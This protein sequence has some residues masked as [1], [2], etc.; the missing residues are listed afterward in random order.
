MI[1]PFGAI[2]ERIPLISRRQCHCVGIVALLATTVLAQPLSGQDAGPDSRMSDP[3]PLGILEEEVEALRE[4][5]PA[6]LGSSLLELASGYHFQGRHD[7]ALGVG[8]A[9]LELL[10]SES[11]STQI[12]EAHH[13]VGL[14]H[15]NLVQYDSAVTHLSLA[16]RVWLALDDREA[17]GRVHNNLGAAHYQWGNYELALGSFL[18]SLQ[19][20]REVGSEAGQALALTNV[21]LTYH[22]WG[23]Y[24]RAGTALEDAIELADRAGYLFG[25]AYARLNL[26]ELR[27]TQGELDEAEALF[28]ESTRYYQ[29]GAGQ[30]VA[31]DVAGGLLLNSLG[32][33][34]VQVHRGEADA[35]IRLLLAALDASREREHLRHEARTQ[36]DLGTAYQAAGLYELAFEH[37]SEGLAVATRRNQRPVAVDILSNLS[38]VE[39]S[40]GFPDR[41]LEHLRA[42]VALRDSI[43]SQGAAQRVA[44]ME[45]Q[46]EIDRQQLENALLREEQRVREATLRRQR[47]IATLAAGLFLSAAL[48]AGMLVH[49]NRR[50][51]ERE[52]A[53]AESNRSLE[54]TNRELR[55]TRIEIQTLG[56]LIPICSRCKR[57][58]DDEGYWESVESY[59]S[60][61]SDAFF[62]HSIC[63]DCG[64]G[65]FKEDWVAPV[66]EGEESTT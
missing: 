52:K 44:A 37:L 40:R 5:S 54:E 19:Y 32:L 27:L 22:D 60:S 13:Q 1:G 31:S 55:R 49:A 2:R 25:Q 45:A 28:A 43:F 23:Q 6:R 58:R 53:L 51:R 21:G 24:D 57:V 38:E 30:L 36:H 46:T 12:A 10:R 4:A 65:L 9:A 8:R 29:E 63:T 59:V 56:G 18:E 17:L 11:D 42:H 16:Q 64:P 61:R 34:R 7:D 14:T 66:P 26:G 35:A 62:S 50:G 39:M 15:W 41:A 47:A 33:A 3:D 20:R 48:L